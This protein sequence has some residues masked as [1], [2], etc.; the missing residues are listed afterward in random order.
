MSADHQSS[1]LDARRQRVL[2]ALVGR[3]P[4][5]ADMYRSALR[6]L[7]TPAVAGEDRARISLI[8]HAMR[9]LMTGLP[10]AIGDSASPRPNPSSGALAAGLPKL[11]AAHP[12]LDL[13]QDRDLIA[14]P[15]EVALALANLVRAVT[16]EQGRNRSNAAALLTGGSDA[17]HP[18]IGQWQR[19]YKFFVG[20]TH[21]DRNHVSS[22][23]L[24]SDEEVAAQVRV[25][26]D[27]IEVRSAAFFDNLRSIEEML[28]QFNEPLEGGES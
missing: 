6:M 20:W 8:C 17:E 28:A 13:E 26:E 12:E 4:N 11:L 3:S 18:A 2:D 9:E 23:R 5:L 1:G 10:E 7:D 24:P 25:V 14:V 19:A 15:R 16:L 21:L 27:V 22:R